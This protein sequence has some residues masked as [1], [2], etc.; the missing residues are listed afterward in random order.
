M[1]LI[2]CDPETS[3]MGHSKPSFGYYVTEKN[4]ASLVSLDLTKSIFLSG[5]ETIFMFP[6]V[7]S[8]VIVAPF[9]RPI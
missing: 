4:V 9:S 5:F 3:T 7:I 1:C 8:P 6:Y 2:I